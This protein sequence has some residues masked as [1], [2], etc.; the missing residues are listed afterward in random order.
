MTFFHDNGGS[1]GRLAALGTLLG[2]EQDPEALA[3]ETLNYHKARLDLSCDDG[4]FARTLV[5]GVLRRALTLDF[6]YGRFLRRRQAISGAL[7]AALRLGA[8]QRYFMDRIPSHA[9]VNDTIQAA[10]AQVKFSAQEVGFLNAVLRKMTVDEGDCLSLLPQGNRVSALSVRY[11]FPPEVV[12]ILVEK[13][14]GSGAAGIMDSANLEPPLTIRTNL[15]RINRGELRERLLGEGFT[16]EPGVLAPEALVV[17]RTADV[18]NSGDGGSLFET[19]SFL[20]G[21]FYAQD[22]GSQMVAHIAKGALG[23]GP[24][25][26]FCAAPG[27]K[28]THLAELTGGEREIVATDASDKR[29]DMVEQNVSRLKTPG[30]SVLKMADV[31]ARVESGEKFALVL[32]DAPCSGLGTVRRNPEIR[33]RLTVEGLMRHQERQLEVLKVAAGCV[34]PGGAIVYSTCSVSDKE[35]VQ[36][37]A[38]FM[39]ENAGWVLERPEGSGV[40]DLLSRI[41]SKKSEFG[42]ATWPGLKA[43][44]GFEAVVLRRSH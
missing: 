43:V 35:N 17:E 9:L 1:P 11:S 15:L 23:D 33:Y 34:M 31:L 2:L 44:D 36:V 32:V 37:I 29:L 24:I 21:L 5:F 14:G 6:L 38:R 39:R 13:F 42:Y 4:R 16:A 10:R 28:T 27:G 12:S 20:E 40:S 3:S 18:G 26:D 19:E 30:V 8:Y 41:E 22:E 7:R 25:L